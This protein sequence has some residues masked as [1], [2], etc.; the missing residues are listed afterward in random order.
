LDATYGTGASLDVA[1][2]LRDRYAKYRNVGRWIEQ[3]T[4]DA[5]ITE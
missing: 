3:T 5:T 2:L 4:D 1:H